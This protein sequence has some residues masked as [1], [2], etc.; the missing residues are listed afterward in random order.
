M[1]TAGTLHIWI[2]KIDLDKNEPGSPG[3]FCYYYLI[4]QIPDVVSSMLLF[5]EQV[6]KYRIQIINASYAETNQWFGI[7]IAPESVF[8]SDVLLITRIL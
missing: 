2:G 3:S 7:W 1:G 6:L 8:Y 4:L 5:P